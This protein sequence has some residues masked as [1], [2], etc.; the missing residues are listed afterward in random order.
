MIKEQ[1]AGIVMYDIGLALTAKPTLVWKRTESWKTEE[2][3]HD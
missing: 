1:I 2:S 3:S